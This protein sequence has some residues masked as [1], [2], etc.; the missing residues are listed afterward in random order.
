MNDL[1]IILCIIIG[2]FV[3]RGI[4]RGATREIFSLLALIVSYIVSCRYY[5][6]IAQFLQ[7]SIHISWEQKIIAFVAIFI[8][9]YLCIKIIGW[10]LIQYIRSI[11]L[12]PIDRML[13]AFA[14]AAKGYLIA[15]F[16]I[17]LLIIMLPQ[18]N[19][20][21]ADSSISRYSQQ[22]IEK[23][24]KIFPPSFKSLIEEKNNGPKRSSPQKMST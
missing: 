13:G 3:I 14:G 11:K 5:S 4:M 16:V 24:A 15:C 21:I 9:V 1:D 22:V 23:I 20:L 8:V 2:F 19:R 7:S 17:M 10:L 12:S 18:G 6:Y